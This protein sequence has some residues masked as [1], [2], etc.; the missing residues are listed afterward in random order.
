MRV[1]ELSPLPAF[2]MV[3]AGSPEILSNSTEDAYRWG[4]LQKRSQRATAASVVGVFRKN[5]IEPIL[6]KGIAV[7]RYYPEDQWRKFTDVD[8]AV[9]AADFERAKEVKL[10]AASG[11]QPIDLHNEL[12][13]LD[14]VP[15][16]DLFENSFVENI[17]GT[18]IRF[19]REED[20]LRVVCVHWLTDGGAHKH[21]LWDIYWSVQ[22]R[23]AGFDWDRCLTSVASNRR[24]WVVYAIG[25]ANKYFG[26]N[27]D[28]LPFADEASD[29]PAW[30]IRSLE[31]E[32]RSDTR[33]QPLH[34]FKRDPLGLLKQIAKR[35]P[36]NAIQATIDME[37]SLDAS[38]RIHYQLGDILKRSAQ[39]IG[40]A[41]RPTR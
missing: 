34:L 26:L 23:S 1:R 24:K 2:S 9:P 5:G 30:L 8:L 3:N 28:G 35:V 22:N 36:P 41:L 4:L 6:I 39:S 14:T 38:T 16:A 29:L 13:H 37:G 7:A 10:I 25:L 32:W 19:L 40:R 27:L 17:E 15:W 31:R 21:R 12:R 33:L 11:F 18:D 20:H